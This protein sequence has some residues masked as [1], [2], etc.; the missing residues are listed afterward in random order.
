L[1][2]ALTAAR[3]EVSIAGVGTTAFGNIEGACA[4][5]AKRGS[6]LGAGGR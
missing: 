2:A 1:Y 4:S 3:L 6:S 5:G